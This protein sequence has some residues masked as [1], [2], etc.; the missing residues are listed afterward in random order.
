MLCSR[1]VALQNSERNSGVL[2]S[3][4]VSFPTAYTFQVGAAWLCCE[5]AGV[6]QLQQLCSELNSIRPP[7]A[8]WH[9]C[10]T[11]ATVEAAAGRLLRDCWQLQGLTH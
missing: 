10:S 7:Y 1:C 3:K 9:A 8:A 4:L 5:V 11:R 2:L 6:L